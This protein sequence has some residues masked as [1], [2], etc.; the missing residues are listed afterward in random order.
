MLPLC[1]ARFCRASFAS[2]LVMTAVAA[3]AACSDGDGVAGEEPSHR[4]V[5]KAERAVGVQI[6]NVTAS[7]AKLPRTAETMGIVAHADGLAAVAR[8]LR[9]QSDRIDAALAAGGGVDAAILDADSALDD[10]VED[11]AAALAQAVK[12]KVEQ[13]SDQAEALRQQLEATRKAVEALRAERARLRDEL[14]RWFVATAPEEAS[15]L[16]VTGALDLLADLGTTSQT[17]SLALLAGRSRVTATCTSDAGTPEVTLDAS[18]ASGARAGS[19]RGAGSA[20]LALELA[21]PRLVQLTVATSLT[22]VCTVSVDIPSALPAAVTSAPLS[23]ATVAAVHAQLTERRVQTRKLF[24]DMARVES[25]LQA[26]DPTQ[27]AYLRALRPILARLVATGVL[28]LAMEDRRDAKDAA[29]ARELALASKV[30]ALRAHNESIQ[31]GMDEAR[32]KA[33]ASMDA[34]NHALLMGVATSMVSIQSAI[35]DSLGVPPVV[36]VKGSDAGASAPPAK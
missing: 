4:K 7:V 23:D 2:V 1:V 32:A 15:R 11:V 24:T 3:G 6:A 20:T 9:V 22:A 26:K 31:A 14:D 21:A 27:A 16:V 10:Q 36:S 8:A 12:E 33:Q 25:E 28:A 34:A 19:A 30:T 35:V 29:F 5:V 13:A 18:G 17:L